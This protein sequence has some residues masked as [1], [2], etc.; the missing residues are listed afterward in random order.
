MRGLSAS[1]CLRTRFE[2]TPPPACCLGELETALAT[3]RQT[4]SP[5]AAGPSSRPSSEEAPG[6][7]ALSGHC[8][9]RAL[10]CPGTA[11]SGHCLVGGSALSGVLPCPGTTDVGLPRVRQVWL[12]RQ[13]SN[14]SR[15]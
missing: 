3:T 6:G 12:K 11:L 5:R 15:S 4:P 8:L 13:L 14:R 2:S 7:S 10:P 1:R 9:V